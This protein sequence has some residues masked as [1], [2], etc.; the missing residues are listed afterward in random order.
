MAM[1]MVQKQQRQATARA[2]KKSSV[3]FGTLLFYKGQQ[4]E[5]R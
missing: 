3:F 1:V 5:S 4:K 2:Q